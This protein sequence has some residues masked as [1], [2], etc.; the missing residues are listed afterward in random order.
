[1][2]EGVVAG[3]HVDPA[4]ILGDGVSV[5]AG[6]VIEAGAVLGDRVSVGSC[7]VIHAGVRIGSGALIEALPQIKGWLDG[8]WGERDA[9]A[10]P[11]V[12]E[13]A[14]ILRGLFQDL[15]AQEMSD[16]DE[17]QGVVFRVRGSKVK[18]YEKP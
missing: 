12:A 9:T 17:P 8:I 14:R 11:H 16:L 15:N 10:Y 6:S 13:R 5:A 3:A 2:S 18:R 7:S 1:M 4:A